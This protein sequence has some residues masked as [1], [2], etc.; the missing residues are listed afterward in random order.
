MHV[1]RAVKGKS[2]SRVSWNPKDKCK[3]VLYLKE[4]LLSSQRLDINEYKIM[5]IMHAGVCL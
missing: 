1:G 2:M 5:K 4:H 3:E